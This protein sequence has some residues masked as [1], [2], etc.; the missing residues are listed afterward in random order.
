MDFAVFPLIALLVAWMVVFRV[1][2]L[3]VIVAA[4]LATRVVLDEMDKDRRRRG[5]S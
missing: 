4:R 5:P 3:F 1:A 2:L